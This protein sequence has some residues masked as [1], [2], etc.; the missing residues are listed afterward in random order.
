MQRIF[1]PTVER[2]DRITA[3]L[4]RDYPAPQCYLAQC[5]GDAPNVVHATLVAMQARG[6]VQRDPNGWY[7]LCTPQKEN[8]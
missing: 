7:S 2:I 5:L 4:Q 3:I 6:L 1:A 8:Q